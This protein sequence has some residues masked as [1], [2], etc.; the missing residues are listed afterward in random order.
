MLE[1]SRL[2]G[3]SA[4]RERETVLIIRLRNELLGF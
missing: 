1:I 4:Q 2:C 3:L